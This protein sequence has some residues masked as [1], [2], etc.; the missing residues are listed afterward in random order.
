MIAL[1]TFGHVMAVDH[2]TRDTEILLAVQ[3]CAASCAADVLRPRR[4]GSGSAGWIRRF[5]SPASRKNV[6]IRVHTQASLC[7]TE[8]AH[9]NHVIKWR[10]GGQASWRWPC[11]HSHE[12]RQRCVR[13]RCERRRGPQYGRQGIDHPPDG[14]GRRKRR[15]DHRA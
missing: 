15:N 10:R 9:V 6:C 5:G 3:S 4:F 8:Q 12:I 7:C 13:R 14:C 2:M 1:M 11:D